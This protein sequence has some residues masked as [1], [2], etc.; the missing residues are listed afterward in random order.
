MPFHKVIEAVEG[1]LDKDGNIIIVPHLKFHGEAQ[2]QAQMKNYQL[3]S[4]IHFLEF[5]SEARKPAGCHSLYGLYGKY[6]MFQ[7]NIREM[8]EQYANN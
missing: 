1:S 5:V 7:K 2:A 8:R 6:G 3:N 4:H